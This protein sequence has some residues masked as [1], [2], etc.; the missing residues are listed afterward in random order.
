MTTKEQKR[1][2]HSY[3]GKRRIEKTGENEVT[4]ITGEENRQQV[5]TRE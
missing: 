2:S 3:N 1:D 4:E 5:R